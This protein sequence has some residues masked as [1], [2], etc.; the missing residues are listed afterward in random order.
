MCWIL[1]DLDLSSVKRNRFLTGRTT[2]WLKW[3]SDFEENKLGFTTKI[4]AE[5]ES[6]YTLQTTGGKIKFSIWNKGGM[7][8]RFCNLIN[9]CGK[10]ESDITIL[11]SMKRRT[12]NPFS[13]VC[14]WMDSSKER[15]TCI[16]L[17]FI[18]K[19]GGLV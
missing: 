6:N 5:K 10:A 3:S 19:S 11:R 18:F 17:L 2:S 12:G 13:S 15:K 7:W 8:E 1:I 16:P 4:S 9:Y 14:T